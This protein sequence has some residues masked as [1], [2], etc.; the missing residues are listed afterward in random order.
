MSKSGT[1]DHKCPNCSAVLKFNP[2]GQNW[3]CEYC[4]SSFTKKEVEAYEKERGVEELTK[5]TK[6]DKLETN[7]EGANVYTC[8]NCGAEIVADEN[9]T[10]TFCVYCK[11]TA[12]LKNKLIGAFNPTKIIPFYKTKD[13]AIMALKELMKGKILMPRLFSSQS[14]IEQIRG[15]YIPFWLYDYEASGNI[16]LDAT[17]VT[18]WRSGN[19][20]IT[21]TDFY[22]LTRG[23]SMTFKR[24]PVDGSTHF[25][26]DIMNSIEPFDY[27][28]LEPF[29]H[30]YLSGFL[31]EKYDVNAEG[32]SADALARAHNSAI[33]VLED[34]VAIYTTTSIRKDELNLAIKKS[35]YVLLPVWLLNVKYKNKIYTFAMNGE[36]GKMV[37]NIPIDKKRAVLAFVIPFVITMLICTIIWLLSGGSFA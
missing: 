15:I 36:T 32:A 34:N 1:M 25:D 5:D 23:G 17:R 3:V 18:S 27:D 2:H 28:K 8:P 26:N 12:I 6:E 35:E 33:D 13:D 19:Y 37:G 30:S 16:T 24:I 9:T 4:K 11:N 10:A 7:W 14:S 31:A 21:K 22:L 20:Q 29:N